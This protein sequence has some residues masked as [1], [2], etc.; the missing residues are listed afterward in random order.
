MAITENKGRKAGGSNT[1]Y[2]KWDITMF[3]KETNRQKQGKFCSIKDINKAW[4]LSLNSDYVR[5]I[6]TGYRVDENQ[7]QK[8]NSFIARWGHIQITKIR[9]RVVQ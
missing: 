8:K 3:D 4:D 5:K 7:R 2:Y 9:E 1:T 6:V